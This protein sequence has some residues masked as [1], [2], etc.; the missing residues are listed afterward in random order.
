MTVLQLPSWVLGPIVAAGETTKDSLGR[1][2]NPLLH[3][4]GRDG[5][6]IRTG[7]RIRAFAEGAMAGAESWMTG[8]VEQI[9]PDGTIRVRIT[10]TTT[11]NLSDPTTGL[12][13]VG[14]QVDITP[15]LVESVNEKAS[16]DLD[17]FGKPKLPG[18]GAGVD[19]YDFSPEHLSNFAARAGIPEQDMLD[20]GKALQSYKG[21]QKNVLTD[22]KKYYLALYAKSISGDGREKSDQD[23]AD[24]L[25]EL[26]V[27]PAVT[28]DTPDGQSGLK[29]LAD[30]ENASRA[31]NQ[32]SLDST[33]WLVE[34][35]T[36]SEGTIREATL[37]GSDGVRIGWFDDGSQGF[38][39]PDGSVEKYNPNDHGGQSIILAAHDRKLKEQEKAYIPT[40]APGDTSA[41]DTIHGDPP[42]EPEDMPDDWAD[43]GAP[44]EPD[45]MFVPEPQG[46]YDTNDL[47]D[48]GMEL[49]NSNSEYGEDFSQAL[50][51]IA[52]ALDDGKIDN[53]EARVQIQSILSDLSDESDDADANDE[54]DPG[55]A[56][57]LR[58]ALE[59]L[60]K[61]NAQ[62]YGD[63]EAKIETKPNFEKN[64]VPPPEPDEIVQTGGNSD[65]VEVPSEGEPNGP[66]A[67]V[68]GP[69]QEDQPDGQGP[70]DV[71]AG[72]A[73]GDTEEGFKSQ[74]VQVEGGPATQGELDALESY[75]GVG[76][77][78]VNNL[79]RAG[80]NP[81]LADMKEALEEN[82]ETTT[83]LDYLQQ[84]ADRSKL[85][86]NTTLYRGIKRDDFAP[87]AWDELVAA[88]EDGD[89]FE[90]PAFLSTSRNPDI[91][92]KFAHDGEDGFGIVFELEVPAGHSAI[93]AQSDKN[94]LM[95]GEQEII[96]A[97]GSKFKIDSFEQES[98]GWRV[99]AH[100]TYDAP[101]DE[102]LPDQVDEPQV[103]DPLDSLPED[104]TP[105]VE[106][107]P[108]KF[109]V[110]ADPGKSGDGFFID[111]KTGEAYRDDTGSRLWGQ[112]G[113]SGVMVRH[114][115]DDGT[116]RFLLVQRGN[117]KFNKG[118]WQLA[119]GALEEKE[120]DFQG[121]ARELTEELSP[122]DG[123]LDGMTPVGEV[124]FK[125]ESG[126]H[127]N[128]IAADSPEQFTP[129]VDG[130]ET[131]DAGW[132]TRDEMKDL[133]LHPALE[134][135]IDELLDRFGPTPEKTTPEPDV[136][137]QPEVDAPNAVEPVPSTLADFPQPSLTPDEHWAVHQVY[138]YA[139][140]Y[141]LL[142]PYLH[143]NKQTWDSSVGGYRDVTPEEDA[144][145]QK[146]IGALDSAF[147]KAQPLDHAVTVERRSG[148]E[149]FSDPSSMV[150]KDIVNLGYTS[151]ATKLQ[152]H[153]YGYES[154]PILW[155]ITLPEG[156]QAIQGN[157]F[158][159]E[160]LIN[161]GGVFHV[162]ADESMP[163]GE[164]HIS[165]T[166]V[167][168]GVST[169]PVAEQVSLTP[170]PE[171]PN[172]DWGFTPVEEI[173]GPPIVN[174]K[175]ETIGTSSDT[176]EYT[177]LDNGVTTEMANAVNS[178]S[179]NNLSINSVLRG[180]SSA[181]ADNVGPGS[182]IHDLDQLL[183]K[184]HTTQDMQANRTIQGEENDPH[185]QALLNAEAG[186]IIHDSG[187][188]SMTTKKYSSGLPYGN[189]SPTKKR[190]HLKVNI[191][192]GSRAVYVPQAKQ[193]SNKQNWPN[194]WENELITDRDGSFEIVSVEDS[195]DP[196]TDKV[197]TVN[198]HEKVWDD[199]NGAA[200]PAAAEPVDAGKPDSPE[201]GPEAPAPSSTPQPA[202]AVTRAKGPL[203]TLTGPGDHP[204][205]ETFE[206]DAVYTA[207]LTDADFDIKDAEENESF[208][209]RMGE[210]NIKI[211][212][213]DGDEDSV[214]WEL[215]GTGANLQQLMFE[216]GHSYNE[217]KFFESLS[218]P[219]DANSV[220]G[221]N[222]WAN[223]EPKSDDEWEKH[224]LESD[225]EPLAPWEK[226]LLGVMK[227]AKSD[228]LPGPES[229]DWEKMV[230]PD[231]GAYRYD[232]GNKRMHIGDVVVGADGVAMQIKSFEKNN[233]GVIAIDAGGKKRIRNRKKLTLEIQDVPDA[234]PEPTPTPDPAAGFKWETSSA[235]DPDFNKKVQDFAEALDIGS[236][237]ADDYLDLGD[238]YRLTGSK[239]A[240]GEMEELT[241]HLEDT[242]EII[243]DWQLHA[244]PDDIK[245]ALNNHQAGGAQPQHTDELVPNAPS[246]T[247]SSAYEAWAQEA[248]D[249]IID[250]LHADGHTA[251]A[252]ELYENS[253]DHISA[254]DYYALGNDVHSYANGTNNL[255]PELKTAMD[256]LSAELGTTTPKSGPDEPTTA[257]T[258]TLPD[259]Y[260]Q[261]P[262]GSKVIAKFHSTYDNTTRYWVEEPNGAGA[263]YV[264][265]GQIHSSAYSTAEVEGLVNDPNEHNWSQPDLDKGN[266]GQIVPF[267]EPAAYDSHAE[268]E[269]INDIPKAYPAAAKILPA[270][271]S[272]H[273]IK[274]Y[275]NAS[276][277]LSDA[278]EVDVDSSE[279]HKYV[280][281]AIYNLEQA[282]PSPAAQKKLNEVKEWRDKSLTKETGVKGSHPWGD[283]YAEL[284]AGWTPTHTYSTPSA[285][286]GKP[287]YI[288]QDEAG[289]LHMFIPGG[290]A[291][292]LNSDTTTPQSLD[293][294]GWS[295]I[296]DTG[297]AKPE[298]QL[299]LG[300]GFSIPPPG[301]K[302]LMKAP[303]YTNGGVLVQHPDGSNHIYQP[304]GDIT[305]T[306][307]G[308]DDYT[309]WGWVPFEDGN[310]ESILPEG[311][312][313]P[314]PGST[315]IAKHNGDGTMLVKHP[316]GTN[317][318]YY[319]TS[320]YSGTIGVDE[321]A[322]DDQ[323][324]SY[325]DLNYN[326]WAPYTGTGTAQV[327]LGD[328]YK[329]PPAGSVV[330][331]HSGDEDDTHYVVQHPDGELMRYKPD[332]T[333][334][335]MH[336]LKPSDLP[337]LGWTMVRSGDTLPNAPS[338]MLP[339]QYDDPP[340]NATVLAKSKL[341][342][343]VV[344]KYAD[345]TYHLH[346]SNGTVHAS[347][348]GENYWNDKLSNNEDNA[349]EPM[350]A[351][352][353]ATPVNTKTG[354]SRIGNDG[355][356]MHIGDKVIWAKDGQTYTVKGFENNDIGV[357][358][359]G[360]DG[361]TRAIHRL[362]LKLH[363]DSKTTATNA[364]ATPSKPATKQIDPDPSS[365]WY[366]QPKPEKPDFPAAPE[367]LEPWVPSDWLSKAGEQWK[368]SF[369]DAT[370]SFED[371]HRYKYFK[372]VAEDGDSQ[373]L[374]KLKSNGWIS[375]E[376]HNA[377]TDQMDKN[378]EIVKKHN[379]DKKALYDKWQHDSKDWAK[380]NGKPSVTLKGMDDGVLEMGNS[381]AVHW[382]N[383]NQRAG[384]LGPGGKMSSDAR[385][386][387]SSQKGSNISG[388][389]RYTLKEASV[390]DNVVYSSNNGTTYKAMDKA[391]QESPPLAQ[392]FIVHRN[393]DTKAFFDWDNGGQFSAGAHISNIAGTIQ[394]DWGY[395]E[396][397]PG[398]SSGYE[399]GN[400]KMRL[401]V[402]AG[403]RGVWT[404]DHS[405]NFGHVDEE[406]FILERGLAYYIHKV[407][408]DGHK[409][410]V[411]AE[412]I[413]KD[414]N[415]D[416]FGHFVNQNPFFD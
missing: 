415:Y 183:E 361:K 339:A 179:H 99:Y 410:R 320:A 141:K 280:A 194:A 385:S 63:P 13:Y 405:N 406:G 37:K 382:F 74:Y 9:N 130:H 52:E 123:Y 100:A 402:P 343:T 210:L 162:T 336:H 163:G 176:H 404:G 222:P 78:D 124:N 376:L 101:A 15:N 403:T 25:S 304:Y 284:P 233:I 373:A 316:D 106:N 93:D 5:K 125:H 274:Q 245:S 21:G 333:A 208:L 156:T 262:A 22:R 186:D 285:Y 221:E 298:T 60:H 2:W 142:N 219:D 344:V 354:P 255:S 1:D 172:K 306:P 96:L 154:K 147:A 253:H 352:Q 211:I 27:D 122:P 358:I 19:S 332:G 94:I 229:D 220:T 131:S 88:L 227:D 356:A 259:G 18:A 252:N 193:Q 119:G 165:M 309:P 296:G 388:T 360:P 381:A 398:A 353:V 314:P 226:E 12:P 108:G 166:Y 216:Y 87:E 335:T 275:R 144:T 117:G 112:Y 133:T 128:N 249:N 348:H 214:H 223:N 409:W 191:L 235:D 379:E 288:V 369:P 49:Q 290:L 407:E 338:P 171:P 295:K 413:P 364:P 237:N 224:L 66:E 137:P 265:N 260:A 250:R 195:D 326:T 43:D 199:N 293:N 135:N 337:S 342:G 65:T 82:P 391:M 50:H 69:G 151:T 205:K 86:A 175:G 394:H 202:A 152:T 155:K 181:T 46:S 160:I 276:Y 89:T 368:V 97:P 400:V 215:S 55:L 16:L 158:E 367:N 45:E 76:F 248:I 42:P 239:N 10:A 281:K 393:F 91:A 294:S 408:F 75:K 340:D 203:P 347:S 54:N 6:F 7:H 30:H 127:Y 190:V 138:G 303:A 44:P 129:K 256:K 375:D 167:P 310:T 73:Q 246:T 240:S 414:V 29:W 161:R 58:S 182:T 51:N 170:E 132:F 399:I 380:A 377:A 258:P 184:S 328:N 329:K 231:K 109:E 244:N 150:G 39:N 322:P 269:K 389:L 209:D 300:P 120:N 283:D 20:A 301:A 32:K 297:T 317:H 8:V 308:P 173:N 277:A 212:S 263:W 177:V 188:S 53:N 48:I 341:T 98:G 24:L 302:A 311:Y 268:L 146:A 139:W 241:L 319:D 267:D 28:D 115:D 35:P 366:N 355:Q 143:H 346:K 149:L 57:D 192:E 118:K 416:E 270:G 242:G 318:Y 40:P 92:S 168:N 251:E 299:N 157:D 357:K 247:D 401:R 286:D 374:S 136:T 383:Q 95:G 321:A 187:Y 371:T 197:I 180:E 390:D 140:G 38:I 148:A 121:A 278:A 334:S 206:P 324:D 307:S 218:H 145:A 164:R 3:P 289:G 90:D 85:S 359:V 80:D 372:Q 217:D 116:E 47:R 395:A 56:E 174:V 272:E 207:D 14:H 384:S 105:D 264:A 185:M 68:P 107:V 365:P 72:P 305:P 331:A 113:A 213:Q 386:A 33:E 291:V 159:K 4:R 79:L 64:A 204:A 201:A 23:Y 273:Q 26:G 315:V 34:Q 11:P 59:S 110:L 279:W 153:G 282:G 67:G 261:P 200:E 287:M 266:D 111:P 189:T 228:D 102:T 36:L 17:A 230:D 254:H 351:A 41:T 392:D 243:G 61:F 412:I 62:L 387:V 362:K 31:P 327:D 323:V 198:Y 312:H 325:N 196:N 178:Y 126:W 345:G 350:G 238:G 71:E 370:K 232:E 292:P 397:S 83:T 378:A 84:Y 396:T 363:P 234:T 225:G 411:D 169:E 104:V 349:W 257:L 330:L 313:A 77:I 271:S 114:V 70:N 236:A 103:V 81:D 134:N